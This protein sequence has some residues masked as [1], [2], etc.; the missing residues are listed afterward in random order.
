MNMNAKA[1][2]ATKAICGIKSQNRCCY[3]DCYLW[4]SRESECDDC[5]LYNEL[6]VS[7]A[8]MREVLV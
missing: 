7:A 1:A 3:T 2:V 4:R 5:I 8:R 6:F